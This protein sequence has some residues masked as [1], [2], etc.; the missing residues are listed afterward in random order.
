MVIIGH[1][2]VRRLE[3]YI[4]EDDARSNFGLS[5]STHSVKFSGI[6]GARIPQLRRRMQIIAD[7]K[8]NVVIVDIGTNDVYNRRASVHSLVHNL[9]N[10][11]HMLHTTYGVKQVIIMEM[12]FRTS[13]GRFGSRNPQ[14]NV[15]VLEFN[16]LCKRYVEVHS[17]RLRNI[18][19]WHHVG[20]TNNWQQYIEDGV[21]L[22]RSGLAKYYRSVRSAVIRFSSMAQHQ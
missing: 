20:L 14:F 9:F 11:V 19:F 7:E 13:H 17:C 15:D 8:P 4:G 21:H 10:I 18:Q 2:F 6:G 22:N 16:K 5:N 12:F 1:S 3:S